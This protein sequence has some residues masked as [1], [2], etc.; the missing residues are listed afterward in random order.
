MIFAKNIELLLDP[1][2]FYSDVKSDDCKIFLKNV[3]TL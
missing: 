1:F 2:T 3:G